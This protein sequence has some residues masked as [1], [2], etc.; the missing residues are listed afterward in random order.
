VSD[1]ASAPISARR[2]RLPQALLARAAWAACTGLV[3]LPAAAQQ[4]GG[5]R[6]TPMFDTTLSAVHRSAVAQQGPV[7]DTV[8]QIHPGVQLAAG[9]GRVR[10]RLDYGLNVIRHTQSAL[11]QGQGDNLQNTLNALLNAEIVERWAYVD[12]TASISQQALSAYGQQSV[13]GTQPN[14]NRSEVSQISLRP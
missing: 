4:A 9:A 13:D 14:T 8:L 10:G 7:D 5:L 1:V 2:I 12:A 11:G 3:V 6:I